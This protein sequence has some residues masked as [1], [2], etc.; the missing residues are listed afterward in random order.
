MTKTITLILI[1]FVL[2]VGCKSELNN[3]NFVQK[4]EKAHQK[5][6]FLEKEAI[7]FDLKL[8]FGG[9]E[10]LDAKIT[11]LTNSS[12]GAIE[13]KNGAKI[14]FNNEKVF[15]SANIPNE[16]SVRFDAYTWA[17]F[18]Q[19]PYKLSDSGT[20][21]SFYDNTKANQEDYVTQKLTFISGTGDAPDDWYVVYANKS[22]NLIDKAAYIVTVNGNK[23][24]AEKNPHV[25][26][27]IDY[28][29]VEGIP[30][31]TKW[32][33]WEWEKNVGVTKE[34]GNATL[35]NIKFISANKDYFAPDASFKSI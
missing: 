28:K 2:F 16:E 5:N 29:E 33:F 10:K 17:Y 22:T 30:I 6:K 23:E 12:K 27:Y 24:E 8:S 13:Y 4:I 15:Y 1:S 34:I 35:T 20:K 32:L 31:A 21:W 9:K 3:K 25:I 7:Q 14:I 19:F 18:F 11:L 26:N